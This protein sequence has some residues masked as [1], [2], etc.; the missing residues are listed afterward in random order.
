MHENLEFAIGPGPH[1]R[2][3]LQGQLARQHHAPHA[4]SLGKPNAL[5]AGDTH[6]GTAMHHQVRRN[7]ASQL[8]DAEI[9]HDDRVRARFGDL[10]EHPRR[11]AK[12]VI[13]HECVERD[14]S[15]HPAR[16]K[17]SQRVGQLLERKSHL[18]P[19]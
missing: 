9:L 2:N 5:G 3:V 13:E 17:R 19:R 11:F 1:S 14:K 7:L 6:L 16:V 8:R 4:K 12:L 18:R 15:F 10:F